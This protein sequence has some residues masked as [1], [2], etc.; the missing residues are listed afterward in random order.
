VRLAAALFRMGKV[1]EALAQCERAVE[2]A[3][4]TGLERLIG[5]ALGQMALLVAVNG[6]ASA[7]VA[8]NQ[9]ALQA[10]RSLDDR[11]RMR[12]VLINMGEL[13]FATGDAESALRSVDEALALALEAGGVEHVVTQC[14]ANAAGYLLSL[15][16][17]SEVCDHARAAIET[18]VRIKRGFLVAIAAGHLGEA[19]ASF[20]DFERAAALIGYVDAFY[21]SR[22]IVR[23]PTEAYVRDA[24]MKAIAAGVPEERRSALL[25]EGAKLSQDAAVKLALEFTLPSAAA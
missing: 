12:R 18:G 6:D 24:A 19:A 21:E 16:R 10:L 1:N 13:Q 11:G 17:M 7:G 9:E 5:F 15:G 22:G 20:G 8:L 3:R 25:A 23:E 2:M 4:A 14:H